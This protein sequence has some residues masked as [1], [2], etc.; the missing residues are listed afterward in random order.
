MIGHMYDLTIGNNFKLSYKF[1]LRAMLKAYEN[2]YAS[3]ARDPIGAVAAG[4]CHSN[5]G[6]ELHL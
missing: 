2:S 6:S 1:F 5:V 4:L 3:H